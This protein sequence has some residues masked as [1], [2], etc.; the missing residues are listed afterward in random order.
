MLGREASTTCQLVLPTGCGP[1]GAG[2]TNGGGVI[3]W[4]LPTITN[5]ASASSLVVIAPAYLRAWR[6]QTGPSLFAIRL[7][8][9]RHSLFDLRGSHCRLPVVAEAPK[10]S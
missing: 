7:L 5:D 6:G 4:R 9:I 3:A 2:R 10:V 1:V 8:A